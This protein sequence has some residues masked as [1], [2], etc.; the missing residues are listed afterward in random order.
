MAAHKLAELYGREGREKDAEKLLKKV[1]P[2]KRK[3]RNL[4]KSAK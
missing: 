1:E 4:K 3:L 2:P